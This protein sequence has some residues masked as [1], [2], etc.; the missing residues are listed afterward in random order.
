MHLKCDEENFDRVGIGVGG[1]R[2]GL[3]RAGLDMFFCD[4]I[5]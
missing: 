4:K 3:N 5:G 2:A 1:N